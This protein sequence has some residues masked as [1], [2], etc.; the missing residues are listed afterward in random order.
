[1][2]RQLPDFVAIGVVIKAHGVKGE[3]RVKSLTD[4]PLRFTQ[5][6]FVFADH[7][8]GQTSRLK[9]TKVAVQNNFITISFDGIVG[10][11]QAESLKG[12]YLSIKRQDI[13]PLNED[14]FYHFEVIGFQVKTL[15]GQIIGRIENVLDLTSNDV[16]VVK[17]ESKEF[18]IPVIKDVIKKIDRENEE[19]LIE[20]LEG[21]LN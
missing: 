14:E 12:T 7:P 10:R 17:Q 5:L 1:M 9:I 18:L 20:P 15:N 3:V 11:E 8:D 21:L 19:I 16:L 13:L 2:N 4:Y 6:K